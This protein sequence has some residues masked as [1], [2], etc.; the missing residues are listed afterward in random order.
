MRLI[1]E[2]DP[3]LSL[4]GGIE[5]RVAK[6]DVNSRKEG[7]IES[8]NTVR[9]EE[10]YTSEVPMRSFSSSSVLNGW[11]ICRSKAGND[12]CSEDYSQEEQHGR[13]ISPYV[14]YSVVV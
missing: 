3:D 11:G 8:A 4:G 2:R 9:C 10:N 5:L 1:N 13:P 12:M 7:F 6:G 14:P